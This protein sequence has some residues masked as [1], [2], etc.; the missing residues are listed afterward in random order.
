MKRSAALAVALAALLAGCGLGSGKGAEG[1]SVVVTRDFGV[2][3]VG[4]ARVAKTPGS[5]T[6]MRFLQRKFTVRTRYGGGFVQ[7]IDGLSGGSEGG[8]PVDWFYYVN[9]IEADQGAAAT[10][11]HAGDRV[12]WDRHDWGAARGVPA[13][14]GSFPEPFRSGAEGKRLPTQIACTDDAGRRLRRGQVPARRRGHQDRLVRL[15]HGRRDGDA[16]RPRRPV[17]EPARRPR[18]PAHRAGPR[19]ERRVR[20]L[21]GRGAPPDRSRRPRPRRRPPGRRRRSR[22]GHA[23]ARPAA[24]VGR[25]GDRRRGSSGRRRALCGRTCC[26]TA[27]R[28]PS[29]D[30]ARFPCRS[31]P[32]G[33]CRDLPPARHAAARRPRRRPAARTA[34]ALATI[35]LLASSPFVLV[36]ALVAVVAAGAAAGVG[37]ELR[38]AAWIARSP[39]PARGDHQPDRRPQR[40]HRRGSRSGPSPGSA[41]WTSRS[42]RW[43]TGSCSGCAPSS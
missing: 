21:L 27:S 25:H 16:A 37:R 10:K 12:W 42:R 15:R 13:V 39:R 43:S 30:R 17:V 23:P 35:S 29:R 4:S 41:S 40:A 9:G 31:G 6:V 22:R 2:R 24:D 19:D 18:R 34:R 7:A 3:S 14:V 38:R 8:R 32:R 28:W 36:A 11:L 20:H 1:V 5:E 26:A 33:R